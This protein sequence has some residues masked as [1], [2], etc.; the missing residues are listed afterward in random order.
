MSLADNIMG[1]YKDRNAHRYRDFSDGVLT[2]NCTKYQ[3][4]YRTADNRAG[5][6]KVW[7]LVLQR[8]D[9]KEPGRGR[10]KKLLA[11]LEAA[12]PLGMIIQSLEL[13]GRLMRHLDNRN[14]G[15][16]HYDNGA[17]R[18]RWQPEEVPAVTTSRRKTERDPILDNTDGPSIVSPLPDAVIPEPVR[19]IEPEAKAE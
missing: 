11:D 1:W 6:G 4:P 14:T 12:N 2:V 10:F 18:I 5:A 8:L 13:G 16:E 17:S 9:C 7:V 15:W 3:L 19:A